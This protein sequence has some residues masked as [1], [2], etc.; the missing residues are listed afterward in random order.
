MMGGTGPRDDGRKKR[1]LM[2]AFTGGGAVMAYVVLSASRFSA[3]E[4]LP[5]AAGLAVIAAIAVAGL[6]GPPGGRGRSGGL[7]GRGRDDDGPAGAVAHWPRMLVVVSRLMPGSAGDRWLAEAESVLSEI[8]A[9][10]RSAAIRS[11]LLS[12]PRLV[13][14]M[15]AREVLRRTR[16]GSRHPG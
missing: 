3:W 9:A 13:V 15:W 4:W 5:L 10:R 2:A 11:Y 1:A 8:A 6:A 12:A 14:M 16:L 7:R